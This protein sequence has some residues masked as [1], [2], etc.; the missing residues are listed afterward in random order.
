MSQLFDRFGRLVR[1]YLNEE[2]HRQKI[3]DR[4]MK[5]AWDELNG[6]LGGTE[7][8][9]PDPAEI[10]DELRPDYARLGLPFGASLQE[11]RDSYRE[12]LRT[13]HPD[14]NMQDSESQRR[15]TQETRE[16]IAAYRRILAWEKRV[17]G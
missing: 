5:E 2:H 3:D 9:R 17:R 1:S 8:P 11:V 10:P 14:R 6:F 15:S 7:P 16:L 12:L 13:H 4:D